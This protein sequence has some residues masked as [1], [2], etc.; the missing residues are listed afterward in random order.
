MGD[1]V[2]TL[3][4]KGDSVARCSLLGNRCSGQAAGGRGK[5]NRGTVKI[6]NNFRFQ[7]LR[8]QSWG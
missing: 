5:V 8:F 2:V 7:D 3:E 6:I 4:G 1:E